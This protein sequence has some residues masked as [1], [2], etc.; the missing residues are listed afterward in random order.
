MTDARVIRT[1]AALHS[2]VSEIAAERS[3][4][5]ITVSQL[6]DAAGINRATFY[7]HYDSPSEAL[8]EVMREDLDPIRAMFI[9]E[10]DTEEDLLEPFRRNIGATIDYVEQHRELYKT[11]LA[12]P[13]DGTAQCVLAEHFTETLRLYLE[14]RSKLEPPLPELDLDALAR[15]VAHGM[16]GAILAWLQSGQVNRDPLVRTLVAA[17]PSWWF[18][19]RA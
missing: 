16:T 6:A 14:D 1:R 19:D 17:M 18:A 3:A 13:H 2:A 8:A 9:S 12:N 15:F 5:D 10:A 11:A 7:K 4:T